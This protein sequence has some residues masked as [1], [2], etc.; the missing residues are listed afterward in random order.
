MLESK[1]Q[2]KILKD[3]KDKGWFT[4]KIIQT[5][6]PGDADILAVKLPRVVWI[7]TKRFGKTARPLQEYRGEEVIEY[8]MEWYQCDSFEKYI[9]LNI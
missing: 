5:N 2:S 7:E 4:R 3:L 6:K 8:K 1:V 9:L